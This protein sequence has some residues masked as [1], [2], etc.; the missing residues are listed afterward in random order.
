MTSAITTIIF[1]DFNLTAFKRLTLNSDFHIS[2]MAA[3]SIDFETF[4]FFFARNG[5]AVVGKLGW[6]VLR[7]EEG[8][9][10]IF[11]QRESIEVDGLE[12]SGLGV[13]VRSFVELEGVTGEVMGVGG[14][15]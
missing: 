1:L 15:R 2:A 4:G 13:G 11:G 3:S 7:G 12:G 6:V 8:F 10:G 5:K 9:A 14:E